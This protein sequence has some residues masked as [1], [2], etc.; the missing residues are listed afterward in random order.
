MTLQAR[1]EE[2]ENAAEEDQQHI[3]SLTEQL[4]EDDEE[5]E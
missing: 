5:E 2:L 4:V 1:I 3:E